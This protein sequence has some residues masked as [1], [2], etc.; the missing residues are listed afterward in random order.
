MHNLN[1]KIF[2]DGANIEE[3][4]KFNTYNFISGFTT[5]PTLMRKSG[6]KNY[7]DFAIEIIDHVNSKPIS[8]EVLSDTIDLME[9]EALEISS[10]SDNIYVKIPITNT[11][12]E[13]TIELVDHLMKNKVKCNITAV[14]TQKQIEEILE[15]LKI[16]IPLIVSIFAGR[17][18][19]TGRDPVPIMKKYINDFSQKSNIE[20]L[21]ASPR[22]FLNVFQADK[23]GCNI[24]TVGSDIIKKFDLFNKDLEVFS[25]ET[26]EMFYRD[27]LD[28]K[29]SIF[30]KK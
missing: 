27:A 29:Y 5:N 9:K 2:A 16:N 12:G 1:T 11:K 20:L 25:L 14:F 19:D 24:I 3:I 30:Q 8:F 17:I 10:W 4:K 22:E 15:N 26:V 18:A 13:S 6:I 7:K 23:I 21:W 28:S